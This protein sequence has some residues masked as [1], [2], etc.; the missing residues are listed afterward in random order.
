MI[1]ASW[2]VFGV[3][4]VVACDGP[5]AVTLGL[6][7][8]PVPAPVTVDLICDAKGGGN[9]SADTLDRTLAGILPVIA[10]R[11]G[12]TVTLWMLGNGVDDTRVVATAEAPTLPQ[13]KQRAAAANARFVGSTRDSFLA[14]YRATLP[15]RRLRSPLTMAIARATFTRARTAERLIVVI[16]DGREHSEALGSWECRR[17]PDAASFARLLDRERLLSPGTLHGADVAFVVGFTSLE[18]DRCAL[19]MARADQIRANWVSALR[20]ASAREITYAETLQL[21]RSWR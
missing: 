6:T 14:A 18:N 12:S 11:P 19:T 9:C 10:S 21:P 7:T 8:P 13:S 3:L 2:L 1:R 17:V 20:R 5:M 4:L 15:E 16:S